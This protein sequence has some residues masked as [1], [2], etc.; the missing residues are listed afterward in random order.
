MIKRLFDFITAFFGLILI[1]PLL[2]LLAML[3]RL[4][5]GSPILFSQIRPGKNAKPFRMVKFRSMTD[6]RNASGHLLPDSIRLTQF[7]RLLRSTSL[8]ELP[9]LWNVVIGDLSLVGPRPLATAYLPL[10]SKKHYRRHEVRPGITGWAQVKHKYDENVEDVRKKV[11]YDLY[12]IE[13]MSLR[14]DFKIFLNTI[15]VVLMG[16]GH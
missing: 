6:E 7:G 13:N 10:Y 9:S 14:M 16:K 15:A 8:D 11:E 4:K 5:L 2:L 3:I 1:S 12:Y